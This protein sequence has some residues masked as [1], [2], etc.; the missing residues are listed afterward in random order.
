MYLHL[1]P[2]ILIYET[3][4]VVC[5]LYARYPED[6]RHEKRKEVPSEVDGGCLSLVLS[7]GC[8]LGGSDSRNMGTG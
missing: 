7:V 4:T 6:K 1:I 8:D 3:R 5:L 2:N